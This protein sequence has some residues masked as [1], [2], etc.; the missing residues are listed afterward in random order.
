[1]LFSTPVDER[2]GGSGRDDEVLVRDVAGDDSNAEAEE[3]DDAKVEPATRIAAAATE[4]TLSDT[5]TAALAVGSV[6]IENNRTP[7]SC[8]APNPWRPRRPPP[9][10]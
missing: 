7:V 10:M 1:M 9:P 6:R 5:V 2:L 3:E 4:A 8:Q